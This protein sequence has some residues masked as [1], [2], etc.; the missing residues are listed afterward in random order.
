AAIGR[1]RH[2][3]DRLQMARQTQP[4]L[5]GFRVPENEWAIDLFATIVAASR[6]HKPAIRGK[7]G[8]L[9]FH[10]MTSE[11]AHFP[12]TFRIPNANRLIPTGGENASA[13]GRE[14]GVMNLVGMTSQDAHGAPAGY[15][16]NPYRPIPTGGHGAAAIRRK[17]HT[18]DGV[19]VP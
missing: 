4:F 13:I 3:P 6:E 1:D 16:P 7:D 18:L 15:V 14:N 19:R 10:G 5:P 17:R 11:L 9:G 12:T 2:T 8:T